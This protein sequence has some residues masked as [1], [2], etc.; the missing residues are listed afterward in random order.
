MLASPVN[1]SDINTIQGTYPVKPARLPAV[2]GNEGVGVVVKAP[3]GGQSL[4]REG[5]WVIPRGPGMGTWQAYT[6]GTD[7]DFIKVL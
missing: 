7:E 5:D 3:E 1:P 6:H 2:P 4:L